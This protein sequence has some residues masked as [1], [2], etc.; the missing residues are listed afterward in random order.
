M[1][2]RSWLLAPALWITGCRDDL[3]TYE[4]SQPGEPACAV[5]SPSGPVPTGSVALCAVV[6]DP[7]HNASQ[8]QVV[9]QLD[10]RPDPVE[11]PAPD[12][13]GTS[14]VDVH[15]DAGAPTVTAQVTDP[16]GLEGACSASLTVEATGAPLA[17]QVTL[18]PDGARTDD[19]LEAMLTV[20]PTDADG[21]PLDVTWSWSVDGVVV[22]ALDGERVPAD[23]TARDEVWTV[24][25]TAASGTAS[26]SLT[27]GNTPPPAPGVLLT[28][29]A[30][31]ETLDG[32]WCEVA[33]GGEDPDGDAVSVGVTWQLDGSPWTGSTE[34]TVV[35]GDTL[36]VAALDEDQV[37]TCVAVATDGTDDSEPAEASTTVEER[38]FI[39]VSSGAW[40][41]CAWDDL[42]R[43]TCWGDDTDGK[44]R[45][46]PTD[47]FAMVD[48]STHHS[49]GL[50]VSGA[51][52][53][54]GVDDGSFWDAGQVTDTPTSSGWQAVGAAGTNNCAIDSSGALACWGSTDDGRSNP[55]SGTDW[56]SVVGGV[57]WV[58]ATTSTGAV[59]CWGEYAYGVGSEPTDALYGLSAGSHA[60]AL[61]V[62]DDSVR[63]WGYNDVGQTV[64]PAGAF[65]AVSAG[66]K[67]SC[68]IET[69]GSLTCW[70]SDGVGEGSP[71]S[72][73]FEAVSAGSHIPS[74]ADYFTC[75][76]DTEHELWCWGSDTFGIVSDRPG[77]R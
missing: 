67:H 33:E 19:D 66:Q 3:L 42:G 7:D 61:R 23:E 21:A 12:E 8:L 70:G 65:V 72:G 77:A 47:A 34:T 30:P 63:C 24:T 55:P 11:A 18:S 56:T 10:D 17:P 15:L 16:D 35:S 28:P 9:W 45:K 22:D 29:E 27:I 2:M 37:W 46:T 68:G 25:V 40:H 74:S 53:C 69:S 52:R 62:A 36:P 38:R 75:A 73:T 39:G 59:D 71:P 76:V 5:S 49:C 60:C 48:A 14:C 57:S 1:S 44:V 4:K 6:T 32:L 54:W 20:V 41:A 26:A 31:V 43:A 13:A 58:C 64:A 50:T 51:L